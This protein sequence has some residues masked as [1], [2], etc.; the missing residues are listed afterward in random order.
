[1]NGKL[2]GGFIVVTALVAGVAMYYLQV[3]GFYQTVS[4]S[5]TDD[6]QLVSLV[7]GEPEPIVYDNFEAIDATSSPIRYRACFT[8][9]ASQAML[10][11]T[12]ELIEDVTP[13]NGP[14]WFECFD[15]ERIADGLE[16]GTALA[17]LGAKNISYGVDRI[18]VIAND[19]RGYVWHDLNN[20]GEKA[21]DGTVVGEECPPRPEG[22]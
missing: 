20:C 8:T 14:A 9:P 3:Y 12:Y 6:V 11:E 2:I 18:V 13:R 1:M 17:F 15:A 7:S 16:N 4:T 21:Y 5:G 10:T 19:G 22:Q